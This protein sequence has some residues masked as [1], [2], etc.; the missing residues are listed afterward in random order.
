MT[1]FCRTKTT[2]HEGPG[3]GHRDSHP[4]LGPKK[5]PAPNPG[6]ESL[7]DV[8]LESHLSTQTGTVTVYP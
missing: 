1:A 2:I 5:S 3:C 7:R 4:F 6:F 8:V